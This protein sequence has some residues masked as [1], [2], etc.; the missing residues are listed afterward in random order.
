LKNWIIMIL[1]LLPI[2]IAKAPPMSRRAFQGSFG[3]ANRHSNNAG[4]LA[5]LSASVWIQHKML[6]ELTLHPVVP[7]DFRQQKNLGICDGKMKSRVAT[8]MAGS[9]SVKL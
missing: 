6:V 2:S 8:K 9:A 5:A 4:T 3:P 7:P 1:T